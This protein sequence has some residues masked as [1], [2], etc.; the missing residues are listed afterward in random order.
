MDSDGFCYRLG[1]VVPFMDAKRAA[2]LKHLARKGGWPYEW[3]PE[4]T[5]YADVYQN[6]SLDDLLAIIPKFPEFRGAGQSFVIRKI[7]ESGDFERARKLTN[8][9]TWEGASSKSLIL[10]EIDEAERI[11]NEDTSK[12]PLRIAAL[13]SEDQAF[14]YLFSMA[15]EI[16]PKNRQT[17]LKLLDRASELWDKVPPDRRQMQ[18]QIGLAIRYC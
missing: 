16:G 7:V 4:L 17:T 3:S 11:V 2:P 18:Y 1:L 5:Q 10:K 8:E 13:L 6:G 14:N 9:F 12:E 15:T